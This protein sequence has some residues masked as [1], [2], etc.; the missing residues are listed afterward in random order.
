ME[1]VKTRKKNPAN[2]GSSFIVFEKYKS[3]NIKDGYK[4]LL[5]SEIPLEN[6]NIKKKRV[7][8]DVLKRDNI[9]NEH[10]AEVWNVHGLKTPFY[11]RDVRIRDV[12]SSVIKSRR[13]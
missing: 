13:S 6:Q 7:F 1:K 4:R 10:F 12:F 2:H 8:I 3:E 11:K 9:S 5:A